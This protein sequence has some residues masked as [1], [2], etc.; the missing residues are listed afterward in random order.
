VS[1]GSNR[2]QGKGFEDNFG[3]IFGNKPVERGSFIQTADGLVPRGTES[4]SRVNAP[5]VM[6]P[7][8][9]FKSPIDG[10]IITSRRQLA[11]HNKKHG[12]TNTADYANG[13]VEKQAIKRVNAGQKDIKESRTKDIKRLVDTVIKINS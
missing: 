6:K 5:M 12:V 8:G 1:K 3:D 2:R 4:A 13:Y 9:E 11:A 7:L 10:Q